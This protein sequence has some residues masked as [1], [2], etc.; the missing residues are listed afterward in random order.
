LERSTCEVIF[1]FFDSHRSECAAKKPLQELLIDSFA[2]PSKAQQ[3][4]D[5]RKIL[6]EPVDGEPVNHSHPIDAIRCNFS[7]ELEKQ[8][9]LCVGV[10]GYGD[11][12]S[13]VVLLHVRSDDTCAQINN[14]IPAA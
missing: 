2:V 6:S 9:T 13:Y 7:D 8:W 12:I 1:S 4:I 11:L 3:E 10:V 14:T 5:I